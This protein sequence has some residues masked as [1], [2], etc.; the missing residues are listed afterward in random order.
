MIQPDPNGAWE[1]LNQARDL[2]KSPALR[3][4]LLFSM[5]RASQQAGNFPRAIEHFQAYLK[6]YPQGA[7]RLAARFHL[8]EAQRQAGQALQARLTWTDLARD[9]ERLRPADLPKDA[10]GNPGRSPWPRFRRPTASPIRPTTR[11]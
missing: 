5:G 9:I 11:A 8:G 3:A 1:L 7:D 6:E 4:Q 10:A 2:A